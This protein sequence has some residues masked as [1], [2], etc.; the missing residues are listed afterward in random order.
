MNQIKLNGS[1]KRPEYTQS[2]FLILFFCQIL[3]GFYYLQFN[4]MRF[5]FWYVC[6]FF[7]LTCQNALLLQKFTF[8]L[9]KKTNSWIASQHQRNNQESTGAKEAAS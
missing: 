2:C 7:S 6:L 3:M 9:P 8:P 1:D 4:L 5:L